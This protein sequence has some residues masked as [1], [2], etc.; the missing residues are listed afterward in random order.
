[1]IQRIQSLY[2]TFIVL[3]SLLFIKGAVLSFSSESGKV[4]KLTFIGRVTDSSGQIFAQIDNIWILSFILIL[5]PFFSLFTLL[6]YKNRKI[7]LFLAMVLIGV[8]AALIIAMSFSAYF[9]IDTFNTT[10]IPG[11]KIAVP[12]LILI[13]SI[14]AYRGIL[15]D[16][17]LVRSYDRLR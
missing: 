9:I 6:I 8:S 1:M 11:F 4:I 10:F 7:Q 3:L 2:L 13:F 17:R 12:L 16:D 15:K 5:I 14:L